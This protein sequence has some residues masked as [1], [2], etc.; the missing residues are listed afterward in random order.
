MDQFIEKLSNADWVTILTILG[1]FYIFNEK[2]NGK[3]EKLEQKLNHQIE[4]LDAKNEKRFD[5]IDEKLT[6][7]D[8]RLCR[9]EGAFASKDC[10]MI[11]E[12]S[13]SKKIAE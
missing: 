1:G 9:L 6:D 10:C 5:S 3:L 7:I 11:K 8:R 4:K 2:T 13:L 12:D